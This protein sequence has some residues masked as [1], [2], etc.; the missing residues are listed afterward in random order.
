MSPAVKGVLEAL[1]E[2]TIVGVARAIETNDLREALLAS[3]ESLAS[4]H[5]KLKYPDLRDG[6]EGA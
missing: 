3:T 5:A 4:A 1:G 6:Q 2:A